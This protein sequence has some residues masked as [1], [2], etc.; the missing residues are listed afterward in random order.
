MAVISA[1]TGRWA[2]KPAVD[3]AAARAAVAVL[4][5]SS[6]VEV[7]VILRTLFDHRGDDLETTLSALARAVGL[8]HERLRSAMS[9]S[10]VE[11]VLAED[12][13]LAR[14]LAVSETPTVF[15]DGRRVPDLCVNSAV[16]W[17]AI[18]RGFRDSNDGS[19]TEV[20]ADAD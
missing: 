15:L 2:F 14:R 6:A 5:K 8:D 1:V 16:F 12:R 7:D 13:A 18:A 20:V 17:R 4:L 19:H 9:D 10:R 11:T 3:V